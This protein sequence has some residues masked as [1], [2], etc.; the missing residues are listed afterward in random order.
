MPFFIIVLH[1]FTAYWHF[2]NGVTSVIED[3]L[4]DPDVLTPVLA[5]AFPMLMFLAG[6]VEGI[7]KFLLKLPHCL[8]ELCA[9][10]RDSPDTVV[11]M[12]CG[13]EIFC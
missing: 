6:W 3:V 2:E 11:F 5:L 8:C 9:A 1:F 10:V 4:L 12:L 13:C 7:K